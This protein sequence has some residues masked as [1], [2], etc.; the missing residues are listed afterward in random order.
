LIYF[1]V[2]L[3]FEYVEAKAA[4]KKIINTLS[5]KGVL[6]IVI[7]KNRQASFV[8]KTKYKSLENLG[9]FSREVNEK[10]IDDFIRSA[11]LLLINRDEIYLKENKSFISLEYKISLT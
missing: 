3:V 11:N 1:F 10:E 2:G 4:V 9:D 8:S 7:Q 6:F 5:N